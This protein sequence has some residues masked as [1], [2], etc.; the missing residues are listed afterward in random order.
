MYNY[1]VAPTGRKYHQLNIWENHFPPPA[2]SS[3]PM[4]LERHEG[5]KRKDLDVPTG[6]E[7]V[8][9]LTTANDSRE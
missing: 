7:L 6:Q 9:Q 2:Q 5:I 1:S 4:P 8:A 3:Q